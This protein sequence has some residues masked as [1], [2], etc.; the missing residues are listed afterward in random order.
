MLKEVHQQKMKVWI[1]SKLFVDTHPQ[2]KNKKMDIST[3]HNL[4]GFKILSIEAEQ[5]V[6]T[7]LDKNIVA[8][9]VLLR[10]KIFRVGG[11]LY[12]AYTCTAAYSWYWAWSAVNVNK[13][14]GLT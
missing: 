13:Q 7:S 14:S 4:I 9:S 12:L 1:S 2:K 8:H 6:C 3:L 11:G 10:S 5:N